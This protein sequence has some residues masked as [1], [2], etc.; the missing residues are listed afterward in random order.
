MPRYGS[1]RMGFAWFGLALGALALANAPAAAQEAGSAP[2]AQAGDAKGPDKPKADIYDPQA[3]A[4]AQIAA[5]VAKAG[6]DNRRVLI[7]Y[8]GNWCGWCHKLHALFTQNKELTR[9]LLYE[10]EVVR[11]DIG[12]FDKNMEIAGGYGADLKK[13]GVPFLTVLDGAGKPLANQETGSLEAGQEH[14]PAK[15]AAFLNQ[16]K[17]TPLDAGKQLDAALAQAKKDNKKVL[18][19]LGAPWCGWCHR[20]EDFLARENIAKVMALDFVDLKLDLDRMTGAKEVA[21]RFRPEDKGGIPWFAILD[22]DGKTISTSDGPGGNIGYP[23]KPEEIA[24]FVH[25]LKKSVRQI[26]PAEIAMI[27]KELAAAAK[28]LAPN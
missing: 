22:A 15:V 14:D 16:Y 24:H 6:R 5:A 13:A 7:V 17:A 2:P 12:K 23:A 3:D 19:H 10:Y 28:K 18:L 20:L 27:E 8:G 1:A 26:T 25:M 11:V 21:K 9:T 4:K